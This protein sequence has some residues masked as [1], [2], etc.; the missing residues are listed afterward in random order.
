MLVGKGLIKEILVP[1]KWNTA[2]KSKKLINSETGMYNTLN[3]QKKG[4]GKNQAAKWYVFWTEHLYSPQI[5]MLNPNPQCDGTWR[6]DL[7]EAQPSSVGLAPLEKTP[8]SPR[9]PQAM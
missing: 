5:P 7:W 2:T 1:T 8:E 3:E 9:S 4:G 6:W